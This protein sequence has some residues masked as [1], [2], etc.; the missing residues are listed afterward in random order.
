MIVAMGL[1]IIIKQFYILSWGA[2]AV[3][4]ASERAEDSFHYLFYEFLNV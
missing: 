2:H 3:A 1:R 4:T